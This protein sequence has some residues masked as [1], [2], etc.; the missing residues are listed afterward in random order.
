MVRRRAGLLGLGCVLQFLPWRDRTFR[1]EHCR[2]AERSETHL[3]ARQCDHPFRGGAGADA[4]AAGRGLRSVCPASSS[5]WRYHLDD[6]DMVEDVF[7]DIDNKEHQNTIRAHYLKAPAQGGI[8]VLTDVD[9]T[10]YANL[11][12]KRYGNVRDENGAKPLYPGI[13]VF[14]NSMKHEPFEEE[15]VLTTLTGVTKVPVTTLS[16]R[17]NPFAGELER[18]SLQKLAALPSPAGARLQLLPSGLSGEISSSTARDDRDRRPRQ[19]RAKAAARSAGSRRAARPSARRA[20]EEDRR[21][22][23]QELPRVRGR[24]PGVPLRVRRR[25]GASRRVDRAIT[26]YRHLRTRD[27]EGADDLHPCPQGGRQ[28]EGAQE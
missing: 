25:F 17:P 18:A 19:H 16:A 22:E 2:P 5:I 13:L 8:K 21:G 3:T 4:R 11:V 7:H 15:G 14:Y 1:H 27:I 26:H 23:V 6:K 10:M 20:G 28:R 12:D 24:V 9:D